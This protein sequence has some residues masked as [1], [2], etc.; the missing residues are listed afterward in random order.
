MKLKGKSNLLVDFFDKL[1]ILI[2]SGV[3][4]VRNIAIIPALNRLTTGV[5]NAPIK[6]M[7]Y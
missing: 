5:S 3:L 6:I 4:L 1:Q 2:Q 7:K